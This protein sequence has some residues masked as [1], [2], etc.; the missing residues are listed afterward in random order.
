MIEIIILI[1]VAVNLII[2][3]AVLLKLQDK[4]AADLDFLVE[5]PC[6]QTKKKEK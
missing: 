3:S 2:K 1:L 6:S 4:C 5:V